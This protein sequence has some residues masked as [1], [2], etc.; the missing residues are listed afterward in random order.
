M[1]DGQT[2]A[3]VLIVGAGP[4]GL[5]LACELARR[6]I[7][8]RVIDRSPEF[9]HQSR[10]KG[11]QPRSLEIMDDL[12]VVQEFLASGM[13]EMPARIWMGTRFIAELQLLR[14]LKPRPD[15]PYPTLILLPQW[16]TEQILRQR[17]A[18][19]GVQVELGLRLEDLRQADSQVAATVVQVATNA[20]QTIRARYVVGCDGGGS[21]VRR[22]A[23]ISF[24][25]LV[26]ETERYLLGDVEV[27]GLARD[28]S[29]VWYGEDN[30]SVGLALLPG[31]AAWQFGLSVR[32]GEQGAGQQPSL[33]LFQ[34]LFEQRTG[35]HDVRL[36]DATW[37]SQFSYKVRLADQYRAGRIFI[38]GDAA[39]V[40]PIAGGL[41]MNT[42]IQDAYNLGW[43]LA[44]A[45]TGQAPQSLLDT[46]EQER[47]PVAQSVLRTS[48]ASMTALFSP[49]PLMSMLRDWLI[50]PLLRL[51]AVSRALVSRT[52]QLDVNYRAST[53][54]AGGR[55]R[56]GPVRAGDRAPDAPCQDV[57]TGGPV[58]LFDVLRG[59]HFTL[60]QFGSG[61][62]ELADR[63][64]P[65][66]GD[67]VRVCRLVRDGDARPRGPGRILRDRSGG[68]HRRYGAGRGALLL[69]R[70]DG[71]VGTRARPNEGDAVIDYLRA[72]LPTPESK[73]IGAKPGVHRA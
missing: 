70:P 27:D 45:V 67:L 46:Y 61:D 63:L 59:T 40:H 73:L 32:P 38:A 10:G 68:A 20:T 6:G 11:V 16:R 24:P 13:T 23:S 22:T 31:T 53:L 64:Q 44:L 37:L 50:L 55:A 49:N 30:S 47:R 4:T 33:E 18:S 29:Y 71:Y 52:S 43:K 28:A 58:R 51:P 25:G 36:H 41:G 34:R 14:G 62:A 8:I 1:A 19:L 66:F 42:G 60:L 26:S 35:R 56:P 54:S 57:A 39:H 12:G 21:T 7:A 72:L 65:L 3:D 15:V 17:L 2:S 69:I 5:T 48:G 9:H